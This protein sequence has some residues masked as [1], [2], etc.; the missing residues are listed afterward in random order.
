MQV[1]FFLLGDLVGFV[2]VASF[3]AVFKPDPNKRAFDVREASLEVGQLFGALDD[4]GQTLQR[5]HHLQFLDYRGGQLRV[6]VPPPR[7]WR[8]RS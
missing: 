2:W 7:R 1:S 5:R 4:G 3:P 6:T 8:R